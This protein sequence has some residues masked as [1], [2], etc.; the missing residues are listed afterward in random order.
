M[1]NLLRVTVGEGI[2]REPLKEDEKLSFVPLVKKNGDI[3]S[4]SI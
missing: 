3:D 2:T 1:L 4:A